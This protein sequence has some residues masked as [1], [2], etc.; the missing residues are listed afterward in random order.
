MI[1]MDDMMLSFISSMYLYVFYISSVIQ[2]IHSNERKEG[3]NIIILKFLRP[4]ELDS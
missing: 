1:M 3:N 2:F 4:G